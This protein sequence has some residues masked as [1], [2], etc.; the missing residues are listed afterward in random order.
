ME[1]EQPELSKASANPDHRFEP[2]YEKL[3]MPNLGRTTRPWVNA[4]LLG[5]GFAA[6]HLSVLDTFTSTDTSLVLAALIAVTPMLLHIG[7]RRVIAVADEL[8]ARFG[9]A[10]AIHY[11]DL[12]RRHLPDRLF[13]GVAC[14]V[15]I[16]NVLFGHLFGPPYEAVGP[17]TTILFGYFLAGFVNGV[18]LAGIIGLYFVFNQLA[19]ALR[20]KLNYS[21]PD[22]AG[23]I[24]F[25]GSAIANLAGCIL[26]AGVL[27]SVYIVATEWTNKSNYWVHALIWAWIMVPY[28][29]A[30]A[31]LTLNA[32]GLHRLLVDHKHCSAKRIAQEIEETLCHLQQPDLS[33]EAR[34]DFREHVSFLLALQSDL[35]AMHT[36]PYRAG[37]TMAMLV[38]LVPNVSATLASSWELILATIMFAKN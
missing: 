3:G 22:R 34:T 11:L 16:V 2:F 18:P 14:A 5:G 33:P 32:R 13:L 35:Y 19:P 9:Q 7:S 30:L 23:G 6:L 31:V 25:I 26:C 12:L 1:N 29:T 38:V 8:E 20:G 36:W 37:T 4:L 28:L 24:S 15:G 17:R 10:E 21:A 27:G